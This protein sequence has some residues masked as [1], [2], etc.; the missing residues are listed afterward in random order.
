M[1]GNGYHNGYANVGGY[2]GDGGPAT[3]AEL[4]DP[5]GVA[6][7]GTGNL[8]IADQGN[9][10]IRKVTPSGTITS[11]AGTGTAGYNG[12]NIAATSAELSYPQ[13]CGG[14]RRQPLHR[15]LR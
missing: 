12:D 13:R 14:W 9:N 1:A 5:I 10:R 15:G 8:Y 2:S 3:S 11:V 4:N 6:V 7:D